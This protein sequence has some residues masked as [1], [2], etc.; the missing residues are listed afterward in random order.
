MQ[1]K[2]YITSRAAAELLGVTEAVVVADVERGKGG[3]GCLPCLRGGE[4]FGT[5]LVH[6]DELQGERLQMHKAR[7]VK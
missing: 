7:L 6:A 4:G 1:E 2:P 5:V 3:A